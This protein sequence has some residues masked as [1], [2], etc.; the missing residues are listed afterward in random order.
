MENVQYELLLSKL[1]MT[2]IKLTSRTEDD[3]PSF[4]L[5]SI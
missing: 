4:P 1:T 3:I 5:K 2:F